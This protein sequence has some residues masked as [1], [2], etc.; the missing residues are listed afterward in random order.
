MTLLSIRFRVF[1]VVH[2][3]QRIKIAIVNE[4]LNEGI[5]EKWF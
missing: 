4:V 1:S 5:N 2:E 3:Y